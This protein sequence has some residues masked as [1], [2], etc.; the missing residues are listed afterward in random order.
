MIYSGDDLRFALHVCDELATAWDRTSCTGGVFMQNLMPMQGIKTK[1]L[2]ANDLIYPCDAVA[3]RHKLYCYLMSTSR[4]LPAV[5]YDWRATA[6]W[7]RRAERGWVATCFQSFGRDASGQSVQ[8][9]RR[10]AALCRIAGNMQRECIYGAARDLT[11]NDA[12]GRRAAVL[13]GLAPASVRAYCFN[14]IGTILG[15]FHGDAAGRRAECEKVTRTYLRACLH[16]A[17]VY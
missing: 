4:I 14:G 17:G 13:C 8:N 10:I 5:G 1:W 16:G 15:G 9:P 6:A 3:P 12:N 7:C 2:K 11:S